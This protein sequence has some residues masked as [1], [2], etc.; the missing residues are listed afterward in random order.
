MH[1]R[2]SEFLL[3]RAKPA[4]PAILPKCPVLG[5]PLVNADGETVILTLL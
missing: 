5:V 2:P 3:N 4:A 1:Y